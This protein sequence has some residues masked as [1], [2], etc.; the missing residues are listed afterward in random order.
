NLIGGVIGSSNYAPD[1]TDT[2]ALNTLV[3]GTGT[4]VGNFIG[5]TDSPI[6]SK[7][8]A[9]EDIR[10]NGSNE[11]TNRLITQTDVEKGLVGFEDT[12]IWKQDETTKLP[13][14]IDQDEFP[15]DIPIYIGSKPI[16]P[17]P[18]QFKVTERGYNDLTLSWQVKNN[19]M[20]EGFK[21]T[22]DGQEIAQV[23]FDANTEKYV[24]KDKNLMHDTSYDYEITVM[25]QDDLS[26]PAKLIESTLAVDKPTTVKLKKATEKSVSFTWDPVDI[27][28]EYI[29]LRNDVEIARVTEPSFMDEGLKPSTSYEYKVITVSPYGNSQPTEITA[30]TSDKIDVPNPKID[31]AIKEKEVVVSW[32]N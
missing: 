7:P 14:F 24:Y 11:H 23:P 31:A 25:Y 13:I 8:I 4:Y 16:I 27:A 9:R 20:I 21:I 3:E 2:Y 22:R 32:D 29:I 15:G 1:L 28:T 6:T 19:D 26:K 18:K 30:K 12:S 5:A 10:G 17:T